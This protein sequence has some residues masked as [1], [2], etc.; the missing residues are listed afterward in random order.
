MFLDEGNL[1][2]FSQIAVN[3]PRISTMYL[4]KGYGI[5]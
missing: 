4:K 2:A 3:K 1:N 5:K